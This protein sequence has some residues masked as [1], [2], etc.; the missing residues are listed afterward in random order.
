LRQQVQYMK[1]ALI[2]AGVV[3][4]VVLLGVCGIINLR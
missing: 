1:I 2:V 3:G 4:V